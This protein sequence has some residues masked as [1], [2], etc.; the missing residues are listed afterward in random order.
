MLCLCRYQEWVQYNCLSG[1]KWVLSFCQIREEGLEFII[2]LRMVWLL[3]WEISTEV[4]ELH[5]WLAVR[6]LL[7]MVLT[8]LACIYWKYAKWGIFCVYAQCTSSK[9]FEALSFF[10][11]WIQ[12]ALHFIPW[13]L[14]FKLIYVHALFQSS[15]CLHHGYPIMFLINKVIQ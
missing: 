9:N 15:I 10:H 3:H 8:L 7:P 1:C 5:P 2:D 11:L 14:L 6:Q 4:T 13:L 12:N